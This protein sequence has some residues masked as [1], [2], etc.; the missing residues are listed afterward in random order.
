MNPE[1]TAR[2][3]QWRIEHLG[4]EHSLSAPPE[5]ASVWFQYGL[6]IRQAYRAY[7]A[8][9]GAREGCAVLM[10]G[11]PGAG[12]SRGIAM[13]QE[14]GALQIDRSRYVTIDADDV[15]QLLL[16]MNPP[17]GPRLPE[18][19]LAPVRAHWECLAASCG[20]LP[21]GKGVLIGEFATLVHR[22]STQ[23]ADD[24][25]ADL[26][27]DRTNVVI[28][29]TLQ[30]S[31]D[32]ALGHEGQGPRLVRELRRAQYSRIDVVA[33]DASEQL[34]LDGAKR[35]WA[36]PRSRGDA[37]ARFT[38]PEAVSSMY[39]GTPDG[40]KA[41][42]PLANAHQT[43]ELASRVKTFSYVQ[44]TVVSR[45]LG[46][47]DRVAVWDRKGHKRDYGAVR[48]GETELCDDIAANTVRFQEALSSL[49][50]S[51]LAGKQ[52]HPRAQPSRQESH[53]A[54][55][56]RPGPGMER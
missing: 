4:E 19:R 33:V 23:L 38:P 1:I 43:R 13:A 36:E 45:E 8:E 52:P 44:L 30:W 28:E 16:G 26:L 24:I 29:G 22:Y 25:R 11:P 54:H 39:Q 7:A 5:E 42:R 6:E 10:A 55:R 46:R 47:P 12:K 32:P 50:E 21:D 31:A 9:K 49:R 51:F 27:K 15:K 37:S 17:R 14:V 20:L 40:G 34:A 53:H 35:R 56:R 18:D 2:A 3:L 41:S 48:E